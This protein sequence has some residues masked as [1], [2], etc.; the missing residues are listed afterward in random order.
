[1]G[2]LV[3]EDYEEKIR[4]GEIIIDPLPLEKQLQ[5]ASIDLCLGKNYKEI[6]GNS[7]EGVID[8]I[9]IKKPIKYHDIKDVEV[10]RLK[11]GDSVLATTIER[12]KIPNGLVGRVEGRSSNGRLFMDIVATAGYIDTGFDGKITLELTNKNLHYD[13]LLYHGMRIC[14]IAFE[15]TTNKTKKPYGC[16]GSN[17]KYQNQDDVTESRIHEDFK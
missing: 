4:N 8:T 13:I 1:M 15:E 16:K 5:C 11:A 12:V 7:G 14:Q 9:D 10:Y 3:R 6:R 2:I 17:N